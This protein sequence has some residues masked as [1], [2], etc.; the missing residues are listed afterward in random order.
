MSM[1][2]SMKGR[3]SRLLM[4]YSTA[5]DE[6]LKED[7]PVFGYLL[8]VLLASLLAMWLSLRFEL[9]QPRTAMLTVAIVMQSRSGMVFAKSYYRL[10]GTLVGIIVSL[11]LVASQC[12]GKDF[13]QSHSVVYFT[14]A[15]ARREQA[16][17]R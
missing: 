5:L 2:H 1:L 14:W 10:L 17:S 13:A 12:P 8:K 15:S 6:W 3:K 11:I 9:D 4:S 7:A 16:S